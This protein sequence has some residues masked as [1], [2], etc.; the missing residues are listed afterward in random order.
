MLVAAGCSQPAPAQLI[1][2]AE[3]AIANNDAEGARACCNQIADMDEDDVTPGMLCR[4]ALVYARLAERADN[5]QDMA[6]AAQCLER[7]LTMSADS[8]AEFYRS[9]DM[10][11]R[12]QLELIKA[13][14]SYQSHGN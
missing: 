3:L 13:L 10:D 1:D 2:Q 9:V 6:S 4:Q 11:C 8:V 14:T 5:S 12:A 7:A